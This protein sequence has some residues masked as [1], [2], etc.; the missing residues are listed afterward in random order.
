MHRRHNLMPHL[1][2]NITRGTSRSRSPHCSRWT[3]ISFF[4]CWTNRARGSLIMT[5]SVL[6]SVQHACVFL[7]LWEFKL[8][9]YLNLLL[10]LWPL[11]PMIPIGPSSPGAPWR[12]MIDRWLSEGS[13]CIV[14][15]VTYCAL[16]VLNFQ[17]AHGVQWSHDGPSDLSHPHLLYHL[18]LPLVLVA[19]KVD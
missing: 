14:W 6:N 15:Q 4:S 16:Y 18:Y 3:H 2:S 19:P 17:E 9:W 7:V 10:T 11:G 5:C 12:E 13:Y 1:R 8:K